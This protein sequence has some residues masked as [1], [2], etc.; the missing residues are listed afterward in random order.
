[1]EEVDRAYEPPESL[2]QFIRS[3]ADAKELDV[4][5]RAIGES[6]VETSLDL[7]NEVDTLLEIWRDYRNE[8]MIG[9]DKLRRDRLPATATTAAP[10]NNKLAEP[11]NVRDT[12]KNEIRL[13]VAQLREHFRHDETKFQRQIVGNEHN[14]RVINYVMNTSGPSEPGGLYD[15]RGGAGGG[16]GDGGSERVERPKSTIRRDTGA[17]T[18]LTTSRSRAAARSR[19]QSSASTVRYRSHSSA[20]ASNEQ[21]GGSVM[22]VRS[23]SPAST[24]STPQPANFNPNSKQHGVLDEQAEFLVDEDKLNCMQIDDIVDN[25]RSMFS[26]G[27]CFFFFF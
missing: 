2:W 13:Y 4:L 21:S 7:H 25:L 17:E 20:A 23:V 24:R 9:L 5:K 26:R 14:L 16:G 15:V 8:T 10:T 12:L 27:N 1:M 6:L 11:A 22:R 3:L 19:C 18:P